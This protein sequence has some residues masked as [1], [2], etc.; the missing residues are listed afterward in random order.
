MKTFLKSLT[1]VAAAAAAAVLN[2]VSAGD[3]SK[4]EVK[5]LG[6]F[7]SNFS[8]CDLV[9]T[10]QSD[11]ENDP[12]KLVKFAAC[13]DLLN[14]KKLVT[15]KKTCA[16]SSNATPIYVHI[17]PSRVAETAKRYLDIDFTDFTDPALESMTDKSG[18]FC[19]VDPRGKNTGFT[20]VKVTDTTDLADGSMAV[21]GQ[22]VDKDTG[23]SYGTEVH[24]V[25]APH[26]YNKKNTWYLLSYKAGN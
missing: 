26:V 8:E 24:A 3:L 23:A 14:N 25:V 16:G 9:V 6:I 17:Q 4:D 1:V 11:M 22:E 7:L 18:S 12:A 20:Y 19:M 13:H 10:G 21:T 15:M 2:P 5:K